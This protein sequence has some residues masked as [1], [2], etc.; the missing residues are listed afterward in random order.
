VLTNPSLIEPFANLDGSFGG[1]VA[2]GGGWGHNVGLS[3]FGAHGRGLAGQGFIEI[4]KAYYRGVDVGS[5]P[6]DIGRRPGSGPP[7]LRQQFVSPSGHG[8]LE[9][10]PAG[11]KGLRVHF[12]ETDD[13]MLGEADLAGEV[14]RIDV[15]PYLVAGTNV[16]QYNPV[17]RQGQASVLVVVN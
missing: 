1:V 13:L 9:I 8:T 2:G 5:Y 4:L 6:I 15:T 10:R 3:Q 7:T 12:N 11:L 16:V 17:G 14:V